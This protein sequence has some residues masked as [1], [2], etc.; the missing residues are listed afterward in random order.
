MFLVMSTGCVQAGPGGGPPEPGVPAFWG[1]GAGILIWFILGIIVGYIIGQLLR[2]NREK[3][4]Y[5][6]DLE[7]R[8]RDLEEEISKLR[9]NV[10]EK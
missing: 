6:R 10:R 4:S 8:I 7:Q 5:E 2:T 1:P 3:G 9:R